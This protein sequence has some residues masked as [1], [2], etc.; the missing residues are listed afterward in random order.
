MHAFS[1]LF[2]FHAKYQHSSK[3]LRFTHWNYAYKHFKLLRGEHRFLSFKCIY[4]NVQMYMHVCTY[5]HRC[6]EARSLPWVS[7]LRSYLPWGLCFF[8]SRL[9]LLFLI[10]H[11]CVGLCTCV[12]MPTEATAIGPPGASITGA[13]EPP[14]LSTGSQTRPP[15]RQCAPL[16]TGP[17][18]QAWPC[19]LRKRF[20]WSG[21]I[22]LS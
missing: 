13:G 10:M 19:F 17:S 20:S 18:F 8:L 6:V 3:T 2:C 21:E 1:W 12:W 22:W 15:A 4:V 9:I 14:D 16:S 7:F 11:T 5:V